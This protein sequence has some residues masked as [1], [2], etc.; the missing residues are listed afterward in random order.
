MVDTRLLFTDAAKQRLAKTETQHLS[1]IV[2]KYPCATQGQ[3]Q[4]M[5]LADVID[6]CLDPDSKSMLLTQ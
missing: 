5:A 1:K 6:L 2:G 3:K 4:T